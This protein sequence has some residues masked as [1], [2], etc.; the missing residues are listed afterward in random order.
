MAVFLGRLK[1]LGHSEGKNLIVDRRTT[2][3]LNERY[4][5]LARELV[6]LK[7][8]LIVAPGTAAALAAQKATSTIPVVTVV[9]GD[10]VGSR[11]IAS[12][13]RPGGKYHGHVVCWG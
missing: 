4:L 9:V 3:G 8:E 5:T 13:A 10:P 11:L 2:K 12:F 1:E 6:D 7:V